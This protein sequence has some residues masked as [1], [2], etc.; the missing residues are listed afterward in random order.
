MQNFITMER[1]RGKFQVGFSVSC[2]GGIE[3]LVK[4]TFFL[5][6]EYHFPVIMTNKITDR[7]IHDITLI[8]KGVC[9]RI[10]SQNTNY[11]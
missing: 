5:P 6:S 1:G 7:N 3:V 10:K 4:I 8:Y 11:C 2:S 9:R